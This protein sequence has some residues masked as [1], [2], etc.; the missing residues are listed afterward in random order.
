MAIA[1]RFQ[2]G[3]VCTHQS[4]GQAF[5]LTHPIAD[6]LHHDSAGNFT[7]FVA[8][9]PI[10]EHT[11]TNF[12]IDPVTVFIVLA[13]IAHV[14]VMSVT[15]K[16]HLPPALAYIAPKQIRITEFPANFRI[17]EKIVPLSH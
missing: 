1:Y 12:L 3:M 11:Q 17:A 15:A 6:V 7:A 4:L 9:H 8:A 2:H 16:H 5:T 14:G 13:H 10:G